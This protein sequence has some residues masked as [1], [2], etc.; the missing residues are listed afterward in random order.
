MDPANGSTPRRKYWVTFSILI[1]FFIGWIALEGL[2]MLYEAH[3]PVHRLLGKAFFMASFMTL[4]LRWR[5]WYKSRHT[6]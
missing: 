6:T 5:G 1:W 4:G 3:L 2:I